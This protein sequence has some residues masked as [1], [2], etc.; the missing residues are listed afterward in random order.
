MKKYIAEA[1]GTAVLVFLGC[2]S[3]VAVNLLGLGL[4]PASSMALSVHTQGIVAIALAFGLSVTAMAY[5]IGPVSGCHINPAVTV[6]LWAAGRFDS[7]DVPGYLIGQFIG[8]FVGAGILALILSGKAG[9]YAIQGG[10]F[11]QNTFGN[12]S[13]LSAFLVEFVGTLIFTAVILG[14]TQA[15]GGGG[16]IAGLVIG[17]T[18]ALLHLV[19]VPIT[20]TSLNPA[21]SMAPNV[22]AGGQALAQLWLFMIAPICGG[23]AAGF[24][25]KARILSSED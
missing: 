23:L 9:G 20:G 8:G 7:K 25:F 15:K 5:C 17:L 1:F 19:I 13:V 22:Y 12:W 2:G 11:G 24:L 21:R 16:N 4:T 6:A 18:L 14:V 10:V 3:V